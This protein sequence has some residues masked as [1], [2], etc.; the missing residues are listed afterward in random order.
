[1]PS[2]ESTKGHWRSYWDGLEG[3][4]S[5]ANDDRIVG[6]LTAVLPPK[7]PRVL[8]VGAGT[9]RDSVAL[10]VR[11]ARV[12]VL[13][14]VPRSLEIVRENA[15]QQGASVSVVCADAR[16]MPF[17]DDTFDACFHAGLLEHFRQ[18]EDILRENARVLAR[19][20]VLLVDVPQRFHLY[21]LAKHVLIALNRWF[22]GWETEYSIGELEGLVRRQ[23]F[24]I[25]RSYGEWMVPGLWYRA[26]RLG[27]AK[28]RVARLPQ[29]P[30]WVSAWEGLVRPLKER[31][32]RVR[33]SFYTF[34]VIGTIGRKV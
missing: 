10:A 14:Y 20:G 16:R 26:L 22:A 34:A 33:P 31:F 21:T 29:V 3:F 9:G 19:G 12:V 2:R 18:P 28:M 13:D 24:R 15:R 4:E 30:S 1:V 6:R 5:Y 8:E 27:L 17:R 11:G 32:R 25:E 23:G 7:S